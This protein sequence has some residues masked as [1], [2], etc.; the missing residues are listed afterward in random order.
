MNSSLNS[1]RW[2][3]IVGGTLILLG[4]VA[5]LD[6]FLSLSLAGL[7]WAVLFVAGGGAF[8]LVTASDRSAWWA[9]IPGFTLLGIGILIGLDD[10]FPRLADYLGGAIVL[11]GIGCAFLAVFLMRRN[12]WWALIP[13]GTMFSL[14]LLILLDP[15]ITDSAWVFLLGLSATFA[16]LMLFKDGGIPMRWPIYPAL[17]LAA[18]ALIVMMGSLNWAV[19]IWPLALIVVG[20]YLIVRAV[21]R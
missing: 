11:G 3:Y 6:T 1:H 8:L 15:F 2:R 7:F 9:V 14:V 21:Q 19:Y 5:F 18:V 10:V 12:Y 16:S 13:M 20:G 17:A 4:L